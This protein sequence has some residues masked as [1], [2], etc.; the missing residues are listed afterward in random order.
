MKAFLISKVPVLC[1]FED[2]HLPTLFEIAKIL[3]FQDP[4][5][6]KFSLDV[7]DYFCGENVIGSNS[8]SVNSFNSFS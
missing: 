6:L 7:K 3:T 4:S 5:V 2:G 8:R 1:A